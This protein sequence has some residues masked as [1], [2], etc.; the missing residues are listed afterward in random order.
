VDGTLESA[1]AAKRLGVKLSTLYV[2]VS[3]GL[4][5]SY[6]SPDGR[7]SLFRIDDVERLA[8]SRTGRRGQIRQSEV[9]TSIT[10]ITDAGPAYRG[11]LV[12]T[13]LGRRFTDTAELLWNADRLPWRPR[14]VAMP[15]GLS[16]L[17]RLRLVLVLAAQSDPLRHD[18]SRDSVLVTAS[19]LTATVATHLSERATPIIAPADIASSIASAMRPKGDHAAFSAG[20]DA[21]LVL[22]ADH[23]LAASTRAV[24][25]AANTRADLGD[26]L[27]AGLGVVLGPLHGGAG[28]QVVEFLT[29][30][31]EVGVDKAIEF[32]IRGGG[33][34]PG[35]GS[36]AYSGVDPRFVAL[37]PFVDDLA[38][39]AQRDLFDQVLQAASQRISHSPTIDLALGMLVW[40]IGCDAEFATAIFAIARMA[41]W[42]AH[43]LEALKEPARPLRYRAAYAAES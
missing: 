29:R 34:L 24:R 3:R 12:T 14:S 18:H 28:Q 26:A 38:R 7:R 27:F 32:E 37:L 25:L 10:Q 36:G 30:C 15:T 22:L 8:N 33:T 20:V 40:S 4:I 41:G 13:L 19:N 16:V 1:E 2:Y 6:P 21:A 9:I 35:F 11:T 23:E 17:D 43:Y 31:E 42:T 5:A 39:D